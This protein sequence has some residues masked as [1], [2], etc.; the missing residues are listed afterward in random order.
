MLSC[1]VV[2]NRRRPINN[3]PQLSKLPHKLKFAIPVICAL[4][5]AC[6]APAQT[7]KRTPK[8]AAPAATPW[9]LSSLTVTGNE[10]YSQDMIVAASGLKLGQTAAKEDFEKARDRLLATGA[11]ETV[12]F[13]FGPAPGG[14]G[15]QGKFEVAEIKQVYPYR[16]ED[17]PGSDAELRE[18]LK[19]REPMFAGRIPGT[20]ELLARFTKDIND[21]AESKNFK[22]T[23]VGKLTADKPGEL[24]VVFRPATPSP[25]IADVRFTGNQVI[26]NAVLHNSLAE[27]AV[28]VPYSEVRVR[29]LLDSSIRPLYEAKGRMHVTFPKVE[30]KPAPEGIKGVSLSVEVEEGPVYKFGKITIVSPKIPSDELYN[31]AKLK[32]GDTANFDAVANAQIAMQKRFHKSG[33]MEMTST[34]D[35]KQDDTAK[36]V[37]VTIRTNAGTQ[38][39]MGALNIKGLD[40]ESEPAIRKVWG[41]KEGAPYDDTYPQSFLTQIQEGGYFDNLRGT[42]FDNE[43]NRTTNTVDVT[44][45]FVGGSTERTERRRREPPM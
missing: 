6:S 20:R 19:Q 22:D 7:R 26:K 2:G 40:I 16:F 12:G 8:P 18:Y 4:A 43:V 23:V 41:M 37:D 34:V 33:Y 3:R 29:E 17:L 21:F 5:M 39:K 9:A 42:R 36:T 35:R 30:V 25:S 10:L 44:L 24:V 32:S 13:E 38:F 45:Y 28:G 11:F 14:K 31:I 27:V 15:V 1:A